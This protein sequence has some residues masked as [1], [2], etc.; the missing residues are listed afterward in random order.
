VWARE[1]YKAVDLNEPVPTPD[2]WKK[3][4]D[5]E[6]GDYVFGSD[7]EPTEIIAKTPVFTD[8]DCY[9]VLFDDGYSVVVSGEHLWEVEKRTRKREYRRKGLDRE[10]LVINTAE[11][12]QN[13]HRPDNRI[14]VRVPDPV[15]M[16][17]AILPVR[18]YTLGLWLGDGHNDNGRI[19][20]GDD[21]CFDRVRRDGYELGNPPP[22]APLTRT[23]YGLG[24]VLKGLGL[25]HDK[26]IPIFFK[27]ASVEQR[28][29]L[30]RGLMD[31]DGHCNTRGTATFVNKN[32]R[33]AQDVFELCSSLGLKPHF[34]EHKNNV[35]HVSFE[36]YK[37]QSPFFLKRKHERCKQGRRNAKRFIVSVEPVETIPV[38]C[39]QVCAKDGLYQIGKHY[40]LTHNSTIITFGLTL[41]D[42]LNNPEITIGIFSHT[43]S[44][45]RDFVRQIKAEMETNE[46]LPRLWP[47]I[48]YE[49]PQRAAPRWS[50]DGGIVV[51]RQQNPKEATV[52]GHG[53]VDGQP[54]GRH[55]S[56]R[57]YDDVVTLES[58]ST[59]EQIEKT[60][61]SWRMSDNLGCDGGHVRYIGT[62]YHL[63]DTYSV[64]LEDEIAKPRIHAATKDGTAHGEPVLLTQ[65]TLDKKRKNQGIHVFSSQ[66]LLNP[67]ADK[68]MGFMR[69]WMV[70]A[71][72]EYEAAMRS[73][74]R[75]IIV[76]PASRKPHGTKSEKKN[77]YTS[78]FVIGYGLDEKFRVL[79]IVRDRLNLTQRT[80][81]LL[82][83]HFKWKPG[84]VAYEDYDRDWET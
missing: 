76:D 35:F 84:L 69:E 5:L 20:C 8:A 27:R 42:I 53:L 26:H 45:A 40:C 50:V 64:M 16:P 2:G 67:T 77:D 24:S 33:L 1:H 61:H 56:L 23:V 43:K 19:T 83:L 4:G 59:P 3:H 13:D 47:H 82:E 49:E 55:F 63:F 74:W 51:K 65:E 68:S 9:R 29:D 38:S 81:K 36:A 34:R 31:S 12:A 54:T 21:E 37:D 73:L 58:V 28:F 25:C 17:E 62:R 79:D 52:E 18:P 78:M 11:M 48:F 60:T 66:M 6:V 72:T 30:L 32:K 70:L 71:D 46:D 75:F 10:T 15:D 14:A 22:S 41:W 57:I 39:I 7:G 44:I 80:E